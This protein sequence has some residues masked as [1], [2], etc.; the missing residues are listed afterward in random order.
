MKL[1]KKRGNSIFYKDNAITEV[2]Q[3]QEPP[4]KVN[5]VEERV[6]EI[7]TTKKENIVPIELGVKKNTHSIFF[8]PDS[9][10]KDFSSVLKEV[11]EYISENYAQLIT[12]STLEDAKEQMKRYIS[13]FVMEKR[14]AVKGM[15]GSELIDAIYT[16]MAEYG[17]LTK[18]IFG[19]G[20]EEIDSATRS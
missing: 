19:K 13:K 16:E 20:I 6:E 11:Q 15:S 12:D 4:A 7:L 3:A 5:V 17:F 2:P 14:M 18:Y 8:A 9:E 10:G 1:G